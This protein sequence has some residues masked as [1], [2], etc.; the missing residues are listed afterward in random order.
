MREHT[1]SEGHTIAQPLLIDEARTL[2]DVLTIIEAGTERAGQVVY[3]PA[4]RDSGSHFALAA[5][6]DIRAMGCP[7]TIAFTCALRA[8]AWDAIPAALGRAATDADL[9]E[10]TFDGGVRRKVNSMSLK[11]IAH[12]ATGRTLIVTQSTNALLD[13]WFIAYVDT[14]SVVEALG[15]LREQSAA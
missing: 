8:D 4:H 2:A 10:F 7:H 3:V 12:R 9:F 11:L 13:H 14:M 1:T 6:A 5:H 15:A